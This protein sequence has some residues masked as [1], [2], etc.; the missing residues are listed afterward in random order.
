MGCCRIYVLLISPRNFSKTDH[1]L[2]Y[3]GNLKYKKIEVPS[4]F[5]SDCNG[6]KVE[7]NSKRNY[8]KHTNTGLLKNAVDQWIIEE[9]GG[10]DS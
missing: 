9:I 7:I 1:I 4:C 6:M 3:R 5:L 2:G 8:R 10:G